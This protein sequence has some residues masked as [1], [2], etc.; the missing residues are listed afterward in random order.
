M[1]GPHGTTR[2]VR[3]L[4]GRLVWP[5]H[6][7]LV[8]ASR[9]ETGAATPAA[10]RGLRLVRV[11]AGAEGAHRVAADAMRAAGEPDGLVAPRLAHGDEFFGWAA[12]ARIVCFG[13]VTTRDRAV[14][15]FRLTNAPGR[16]FLYNFHTLPE[17]R[18]RGLGVAL[19]DAIRWVLGNETASEFVADVN[20]RNAPSRRCLE[21]SGFVPVGRVSF[22]TLLKRWR[23][24]LR[25]T[26][27]ER[28]GVSLF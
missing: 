20:V 22:L 18:G 2:I 1:K 12:G 19:H 11:A 3:G 8:W 27:L 16:V 9:Y 24:P 7:L 10:P 14:G 28:H 4:L 5:S 25:R 13:W 6:N 21:K 17:H 23:C 26:S 15:P